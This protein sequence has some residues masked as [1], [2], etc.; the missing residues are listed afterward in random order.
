MTTEPLGWEFARW[1]RKR[2][3]FESRPRHCDSVRFKSLL[4]GFEFV[5]RTRPVLVQQAGKRAIGE[6][7]A[8]SLAGR[9]IVGLVAGIADALDLGPAARARLAIATVNCHAGTKR[10]NLL[11][12][13][14]GGFGAQAIGPFEQRRTRGAV[15]SFDLLDTQLLRHCDG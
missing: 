8:A 1:G 7:A 6:Q 4:E 5:K 15:E 2:C 14:A 13:C 9:T 12:K 10:S 11:R 3:G